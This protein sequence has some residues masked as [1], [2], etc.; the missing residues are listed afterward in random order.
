[1]ARTVSQARLAFISVYGASKNFITPRI[2]RYGWTGKRPYELSEGT[3]LDYLPVF[4][5]T[6]LEKTKEGWE[7]SDLSQMHSSKLDAERFLRAC[8][9]EG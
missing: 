3:D 9:V 5:T 2:I 4:G 7:R 8:G 1:M 6:L